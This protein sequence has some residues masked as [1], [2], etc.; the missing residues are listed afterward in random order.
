VINYVINIITLEKVDK[1][2]IEKIDGDIIDE[3][4]KDNDGEAIARDVRKTL[5]I[6]ADVNVKAITIAIVIEI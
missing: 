6:I 2:A 1:K 4:I 3:R 5:V